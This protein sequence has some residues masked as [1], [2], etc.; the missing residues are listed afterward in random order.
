MCLAHIQTQPPNQ[1]KYY[2]PKDEGK[3][4]YFDKY[5]SIEINIFLVQAKYWKIPFYT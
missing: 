3:N 4:I 2:P 5:I 1:E